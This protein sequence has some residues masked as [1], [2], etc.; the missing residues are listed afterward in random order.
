MGLKARFGA[1]FSQMFQAMGGGAGGPGEGMIAKLEATME[2]VKQVSR[3]NHSARLFSVRSHF[4][5]CV[6]RVLL[7]TTGKH[8]VQGSGADNFYLRVHSRVSVAL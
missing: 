6:R 7:H 8:P 1:M 2:L 5:R 3:K 4:S